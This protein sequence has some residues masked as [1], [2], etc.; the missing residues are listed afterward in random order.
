MENREATADQIAFF[1]EHG[2]IVVED[3]V[4]EYEA[5]LLQLPALA[6]VE[7]KRLAH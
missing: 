2:W 4:A 1:R 3:A 6:C 5:A 7:A